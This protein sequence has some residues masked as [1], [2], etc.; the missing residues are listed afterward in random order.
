MAPKAPQTTAEATGQRQFARFQDGARGGCQLLRWRRGGG[1]RASRLSFPVFLP[2]EARFASPC[3]GCLLAGVVVPAASRLE[4]C[5]SSAAGRYCCGCWGLPSA[6]WKV[7]AGCDPGWGRQA[8]VCELT[9]RRGC[10][11]GQRFY[12]REGPRRAPR[13]LLVSLSALSR[14]LSLGGPHSWSAVGDGEPR[15]WP[16]HF[17]APSAGDLSDGSDRVLALSAALCYYG[18]PVVINCNSN[19]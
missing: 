13:R 6:A 17:K 1:A 18:E 5:G 4:P 19:K 9:G 2:L 10:P 3:T 12:L 7:S 14:P 15:G 11:P 16:G 8:A